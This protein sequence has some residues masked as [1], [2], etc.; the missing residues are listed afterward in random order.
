MRTV[1]IN[2]LL[3]ISIDEDLDK[4]ACIEKALTVYQ[5]MSHKEIGEAVQTVNDTD[6][7][8]LDDD[9]EEM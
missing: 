5:N 7:V 3:E 1:Q 4:Y 9:G 2:L 8:V 6:C